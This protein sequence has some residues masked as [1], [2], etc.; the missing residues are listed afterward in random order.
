MSAEDRLIDA[1]ASWRVAI[2]PSPDLLARLDGKAAQMEARRTRNKRIVVGVAAAM[3]VA[4][5]L[6]VLAVA[7]SSSTNPAGQSKQLFIK[8]A[9]AI[10]ATA[11][12]QARAVPT[13]NGRQT[14]NTPLH[15]DPNAVRRVRT[16]TL[17]AIAELRALK[18]PTRDRAT[19]DALLT[20]LAIPIG[21]SETLNAVYAATGYS[22]S[23]ST[24]LAAIGADAQER[25]L[26]AKVSLDYGLQKCGGL[27]YG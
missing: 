15:S 20:Q 13:P 23:A 3:V 17:S 16:I 11:I 5:A 6:G 10:C 25:S 8:Q 27:V 9:D 21:S 24:T 18:E 26:A 2:R 14:D 19:I 1:F 4:L 12:A 22:G 7:R